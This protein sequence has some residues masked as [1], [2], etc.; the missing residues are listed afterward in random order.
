MSLKPLKRRRDDERT[1]YTLLALA[2]I[3]LL[4]LAW[5]AAN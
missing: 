3:A 1:P 5:C 4:A 2:V